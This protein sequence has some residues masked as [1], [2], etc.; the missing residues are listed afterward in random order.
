MH[1]WK[2][3]KAKIGEIQAFNFLLSCI[4]NPNI[5]SVI[6]FNMLHLAVLHF[7]ENSTRRQAKNKNGD[8]IYSVSFPKGR[9][10]KG[11]AKEVKFYVK[12]TVSRCKL[13][14]FITEC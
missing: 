9:H 14:S 2:Q 10:G 8:L 3:G 7:N 13:T 1:R 4:Y 11:V 5:N 12:Q 6:F